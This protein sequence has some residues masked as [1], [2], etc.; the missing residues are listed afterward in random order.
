LPGGGR[1]RPGR[2]AARV[3]ARVGEADGQAF[4]RLDRGRLLPHGHA[5]S[6]ERARP[7]REDVQR[8]RQ[9]ANIAIIRTSASSPAPRAERRGRSGSTGTRS[10]CI[11]SDMKLAALDPFGSLRGS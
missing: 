7:G 2:E 3:A 4:R 5:A 6:G 8:R 10:P 11:L 9:A 1:H